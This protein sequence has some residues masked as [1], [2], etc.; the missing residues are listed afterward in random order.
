M[1]SFVNVRI[2]DD[3]GWDPNEDFFIQ[4]FDANHGQLL[5]G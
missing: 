1:V 4:L 5:E 2:I 3:L